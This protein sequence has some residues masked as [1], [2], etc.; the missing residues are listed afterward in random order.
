M[1][2]KNISTIDGE[3]FSVQFK[4]RNP[5]ERTYGGEVVIVKASSVKEARVKA[6]RRVQGA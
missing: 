6:R 1:E 5:I 2:I 3:F 4:P